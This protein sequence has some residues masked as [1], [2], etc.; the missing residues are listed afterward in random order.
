MG[1]NYHKNY[2]HPKKSENSENK[3]EVVDGQMTIEEVVNENV[4]IEDDAVLTENEVDE[5][6]EEDVMD[7][8]VTD[9]G[10]FAIG[11]VTGCAKLNVREKAEANSE[12][13][14]IINNG[15]EV[16]INLDCEGQPEP[17]DV[18]FYKVTTASGVEGYC[19]T[20]YIEI[21]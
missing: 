6:N 5:L 17:S 10:S 18:S 3:V 12:V 1:H 7:V 4:V 20:K 14:L 8:D 11:V 13:L 16:T 21:K 19:M 15:D 2:F 9:E